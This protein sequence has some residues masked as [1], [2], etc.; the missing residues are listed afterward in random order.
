MIAA[1]SECFTRRLFGLL[2]LGRRRYLKINKKKR[3]IR[4]KRKRRCIPA[5]EGPSVSGLVGIGDHLLLPAT[6]LG[7]IGIPANKILKSNKIH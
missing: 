4:K 5:E 1:R 3:K 7:A 2:I 6:H